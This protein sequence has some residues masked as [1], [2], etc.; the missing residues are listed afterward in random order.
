MHQA[1]KLNLDQIEAFLKAS[2]EIQFEGKTQGQIYHWIE[3]VMGR[4]PYVK[5]RRRARGLLRQYLQRITGMSRAQVTR[6]IGRYLTH[7][8]IQPVRYRRHSFPQRFSRADAELLATV[9]EAHETLSGPA[10]RRIL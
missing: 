3:Q 2:E 7:G 6:L 9:D 10:T 4:Q 8:E 5:Q 1:E